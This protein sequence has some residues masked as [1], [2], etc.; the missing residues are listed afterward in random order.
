MKRKKLRQTT[1][2]EFDFEKLDLIQKV[3]VESEYEGLEEVKENLENYYIEDIKQISYPNAIENR[4][5]ISKKKQKRI[6]KLSSLM[7]HKLLYLMKI[8]KNDRLDYL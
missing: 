3:E 1:I 7:I 8:K 2:K 4:I 5:I 6:I